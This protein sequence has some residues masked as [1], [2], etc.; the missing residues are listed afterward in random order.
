MKEDL[1]FIKKC[2]EN[3]QLRTTLS[4]DFS[5]CLKERKETDKFSPRSK[6]SK[7]F[8]ANMLKIK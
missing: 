3:K 8:R 5:K 4:P 1:D 6:P 2:M 7:L